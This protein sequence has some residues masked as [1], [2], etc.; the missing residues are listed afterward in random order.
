MH[1]KKAAFLFVNSEDNLLVAESDFSHDL[2]SLLQC[3]RLIGESVSVEMALTMEMACFRLQSP[4]RAAEQI[5]KDLI[6]NDT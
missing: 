3:L 2:L 4:E 5:L 6:A 1:Y